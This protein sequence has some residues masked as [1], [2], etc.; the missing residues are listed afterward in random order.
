VITPNKEPSPEREEEKRSERPGAKEEARAREPRLDVP[1]PRLDVPE[2]RLDVPEPRLDA[3]FSPRDEALEPIAHI[4]NLDSVASV[5]AQR[6]L[7][8]DEAYRFIARLLVAAW[9]G[10]T[11]SR[12]DD[13][14]PR[15]LEIGKV[16]ALA[17]EKLV[18]PVNP[19]LSGEARRTDRVRPVAAQESKHV[20]VERD[21]AQE[22]PLASRR[23]PIVNRD[24]PKIQAAG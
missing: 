10:V 11:G 2:P 9:L 6:A 24:P 3:P 15:R 8:L 13:L 21:F 14:E 17:L 18:G 7:A 23:A 1:E 22:Q 5:V 4:P 16:E 20:A 19:V 12:L